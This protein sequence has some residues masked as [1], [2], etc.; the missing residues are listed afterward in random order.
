MQL[1]PLLHT[2]CG[3][4]GVASDTLT[5][6]P[7]IVAC[8][9]ISI[10]ASATVT[11]HQSLP[12]LQVDFHTQ[13]ASRALAKR[14]LLPISREHQKP[15]LP[16]GKLI[17]GSKWPL[18]LHEYH[19]APRKCIS[20]RFPSQQAVHVT[21]PRSWLSGTNRCLPPPSASCLQGL[22]MRLD[23]QIRCLYFYVVASCSWQSTTS[24][25]R[26]CEC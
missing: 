17:H 15:P 2:P 5:F 24:L 13:Y 21:F 22:M 14:P 18:G 1:R 19:E 20:C 11:S 7:L 25:I 8:H 16:A 12:K 26:M 23:C 3:F 4:P 10:T 6:R 9:G